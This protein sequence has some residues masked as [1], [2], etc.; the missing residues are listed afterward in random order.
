M[1]TFKQ[2]LAVLVLSTMGLGLIGLGVMLYAIWDFN[3]RI[4]HNFEQREKICETAV[5]RCNSYVIIGRAEAA[6]PDA[7]FVFDRLKSPYTGNVTQRINLWGIE[8]N[9]THAIHTMAVINDFIH[10]HG[11]WVVCWQRHEDGHTCF[12][13]GEDAPTEP[14]YYQQEGD[15]ALHLLRVGYA[16]FRPDQTTLPLLPMAYAGIPQV[17]CLLT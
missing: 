12:G 7:L 14:E 5:D 4:A 15:I 10:E 16:K 8:N 2:L 17:A 11:P 3:Q 9:K 13:V 1:K 6:G